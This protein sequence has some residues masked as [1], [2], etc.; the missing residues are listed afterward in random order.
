MKNNKIKIKIALKNKI[1]EKSI[2]MTDFFSWNFFDVVE[3][4]YWK[5]C[6]VLS[7]G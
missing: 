4:N 7:L 1:N 2:L 3:M 5:R 6:L